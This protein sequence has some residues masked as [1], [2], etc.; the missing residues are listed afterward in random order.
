MGLVLG[1]WK[2]IGD[3]MERNDRR[4]DDVNLIKRKGEKSYK[5]VPNALNEDRKIKMKL[6][7]QTDDVSS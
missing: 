1:R 2:G 4:K 6:I 3:V 7:K 5:V